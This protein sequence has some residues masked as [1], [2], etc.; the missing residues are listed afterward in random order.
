MILKKWFVFV[1]QKVGL[2]L[3]I[4]N[5]PLASYQQVGALSRAGNRAGRA[6]LDQNWPGF[7]WPKL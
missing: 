2:K 3:H 1:G 4:L 6:G 7:L 5:K